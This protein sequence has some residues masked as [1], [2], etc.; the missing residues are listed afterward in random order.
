MATPKKTYPYAIYYKD[1][2]YMIYNL[3]RE[4]YEHIK[5]VLSKPKTEYVTVAFTSVGILLLEDVRSIIEQKPEPAPAKLQKDDGDPALSLEERAW[6]NA[7]RE[8][9]NDEEDYH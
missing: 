2:T 8:N 5:D 7:Q 1:S 4:D 9:Q 3:T 6:L